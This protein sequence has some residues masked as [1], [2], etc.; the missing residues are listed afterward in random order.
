MSLIDLLQQPQSLSSLVLDS[1]SPHRRDDA[2][3]AR[4][5]HCCRKVHDLVRLLLVALGCLTR[6]QIREPALVEVQIH[7][8]RHRQLA[9]AEVEAA[10][11]RVIEVLGS[12][13]CEMH[14]VHRLDPVGHA[15]HRGGARNGFDGTAG[16]TGL[17]RGANVAHL[18][19][20]VM[21]RRHG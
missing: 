19:V 5:Q 2:L 6:R 3:E 17:R 10:L 15:L 21:K 18:P 7:Q 14:E 4:M 1:D 12:M 11:K 13:A 16:P 8:L 20:N 9:V